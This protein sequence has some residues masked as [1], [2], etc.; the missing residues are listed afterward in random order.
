MLDVINGLIAFCERK[1]ISRVIELTGAVKDRGLQVD[2][3][4]ALP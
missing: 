4:E 3:L 2:K 1:R